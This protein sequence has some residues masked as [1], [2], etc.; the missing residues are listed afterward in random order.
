[1]LAAKHVLVPPMV[2]FCFFQ[3]TL[4]KLP[5][6]KLHPILI[7]HGKILAESCRKYPIDIGKLSKPS[8][9]VGAIPFMCSLFKI[10]IAVYI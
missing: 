3:E 1:M 7:H 9:L 8:I 2:F 4:R 5:C 10:Y 6:K